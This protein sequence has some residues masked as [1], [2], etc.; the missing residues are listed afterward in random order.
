MEESAL[1]Q[2]TSS[3]TASILLHEEEVAKTPAT[4]P[5]NITV[6]IRK[7]KRVIHFSDGVLEEY[8][9]DEEDEDKKAVAEPTVDPKTLP[10]IPYLWYYTVVA[11]TKTIGAC[12]FLGE[13]LAYFLGITSPKY[14]FAINEYNRLTEEE[15]KT[16]DL[17][18]EEKEQRRERIAMMQA[19]RV[20]AET[21]V[22]YSAANPS[23]GTDL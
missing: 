13:K 18:Q 5:D 7:P 8:T 3:A 19:N 1:S 9:S 20:Y 17:D 21:T 4:A 16:L 14:Q 2:T 6:G 22:P 15:R 11:A 12:D 10:W 23:L